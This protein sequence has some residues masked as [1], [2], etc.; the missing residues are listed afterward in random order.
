MAAIS[1]TPGCPCSWSFQPDRWSLAI[2]TQCVMD[3]LVAFWHWHD[4]QSWDQAVLVASH[5]RVDFD[6]LAAYAATEGA[7]PREVTRLRMQA[8]QSR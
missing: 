7:D 6:E 4:R 8:N 3:R 2:E 5:Q 1:R